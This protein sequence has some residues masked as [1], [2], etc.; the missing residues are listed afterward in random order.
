MK[1]AIPE[2]RRYV[3][4][5]VPLKVVV[6]GSGWE[7]DLFSKN[8]SPIGIR[9]QNT[10]PVK[11]GSIVNMTLVVPTRKDPLK[12]KGKVMWQEKVSIEDNAPY[13]T[14]VEFIK[15]FEK[16]KNTLLKFL[17]DILY[18]SSYVSKQ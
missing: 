3:R 15:I 10:H 6:K 12:I 2:R 5:E 9:F 7:E 8:I 14:G 17:C 13:D 4:I 11:S 16:D 1:L 18:G